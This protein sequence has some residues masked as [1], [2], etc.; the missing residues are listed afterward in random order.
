MR[1]SR[2][3]L[4]SKSAG[5]VQTDGQKATLLEKRATLLY[6][7]DK[8]RQIQAIYMPGVL[9]IETTDPKSPQRVKAELITLWLPSQLDAKGRNTICLGGV[10]NSETELRLAQLEDSLDDLR[11][12]RRTRRGLI[13]FHKVQ[14]A[15]QGQKTQT[16]SQAAMRAIQDR[17]DRYVRRYR[18]ARDAL[19]CLNA[20]GKWREL[21]RPLTNDD[22]RGPGKEQEEA[23]GSDGKYAPSWIWRFTT[24]A[25]SPDEVNEDMR[26]EWAQCV[27]RADRWEEEQTLLQEEMRRVVEFLEWRSGDWLTKVDLRTDTITPAVRSGLSA[28]ARKQGTIFHRIAVR[29]CRLWRSTLVSLSLP[30]SW[31]TKF[32]D[33][34]KEPHN[35][36]GLKKKKR[37]ERPPVT[38]AKPLDS[39]AAP[40]HIAP[41]PAH[42]ETVNY[43]ARVS[44]VD[45]DE[46]PSE[47]DGSG[48]ES[49]SSLSE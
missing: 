32:L 33:K 13:L 34:H 11:R 40:P 21:Y 47:D 6:L 3:G 37:S 15:G 31:A 35:D 16:K 4:L 39:A 46:T 48:Y 14:L 49:T 18:T 44:D 30:H 7:I 22:N 19:L 45:S 42:P 17:I 38:H 26:V 9:N 5:E 23:S 24:T 12:A 2:H 29:F 43:E 28:Y 25:I 36:P 27:A 20:P 41:L 1:S 8:W 10:V